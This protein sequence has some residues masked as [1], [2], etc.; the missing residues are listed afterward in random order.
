MEE[1]L[2]YEQYQKMQ[3][4][5]K[6]FISAM[7]CGYLKIAWDAFRELQALGIPYESQS[8]KIIIHLD[9]K[10]YSLSDSPEE[11]LQERANRAWK[12][13]IS[14]QES[15][16]SEAEQA[17]LS[18]QQPDLSPDPVLPLISPEAA[19]ISRQLAEDPPEMPS[20]HMETQNTEKDPFAGLDAMLSGQREAGE[21][22]HEDANDNWGVPAQPQI[23][24]PFGDFG[25]ELDELSREFE[26]TA[27]KPTVDTTVQ[28]PPKGASK[29]EK[30]GLMSAIDELNALV[31]FGRSDATG[32]SVRRYATKKEETAQEHADEG[33]QPPL[34]TDFTPN[35]QIALKDCVYSM[36]SGEVY[37]ETSLRKHNIYFMIAPFEISDHSPSSN[38]LLYAYFN[39][40]NYATTSLNN[41]DKNSLLFQVGEYQFLARG[42]FTD[43][44]W[45]AQIQL[46]G[47][48][49]RRHDILDI[50]KTYHN[51]PSTLGET[52]GHIRFRYQGYINRK[53]LVSTGCVNVFPID[54]NSGAFIIVRCMED[55]TDIFYTDDVDHV[56]LYTAEGKKNLTIKLENQ[57]AY[58]TLADA[59]EEEESE[60]HE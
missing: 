16:D 53:E 8:G 26:V 60:L 20:F 46:T 41:P 57:I 1:T 42:K 10:T 58:A 59:P 47:D 9:G 40:Q 50:K 7:D 38:I 37:G 19:E 5:T 34:T 56:T 14:R 2:F 49:L 52:N 24:D 4:L 55:F 29:K 11:S 6:I 32:P 21:I 30:D 28:L 12:N 35:H 45:S 54:V 31:G 17:I 36:F 48:S 33:F 22:Y 44:K 25:K 51:N 27:A 43:G 3:S 23:A 15:S 18:W 39:G 13:E